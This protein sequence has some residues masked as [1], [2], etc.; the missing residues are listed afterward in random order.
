MC[1]LVSGLFSRKAV[2]PFGHLTMTPTLISSLP[3]SIDSPSPIKIFLLSFVLKRPPTAI[4]SSPS[5]LGVV[6]I[7][8]NFFLPC[9][10]STKPPTEIIVFSSAKIVL[11][12][13]NCVE[14]CVF[15]NNAPIAP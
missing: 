14:P 12:G 6:S 2:V 8:T 5:S 7:C 10:V 9:G 3:D 1:N 15:L 11:V 4:S 13:M